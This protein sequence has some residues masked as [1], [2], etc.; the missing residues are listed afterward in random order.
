[1]IKRLLLAVTI[2]FSVPSFAQAAATG[3]IVFTWTSNGNPTIPAC[4]SSVTT[5][6]LTT[7]TLSDITSVGSPIVISSTIPSNVLT[8][9]LTPLPSVGNH[10]YSLIISAKDQSGNSISSSP[11]TATVAVPSFTLSPPNGF[12]GVP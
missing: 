6:C 11:V 3:N 4:S 5:S 12:T 7:F 2:L 1:M 9:T 10:T 8:Y